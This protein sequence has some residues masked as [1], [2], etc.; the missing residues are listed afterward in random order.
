MR[1]LHFGRFHSETNP[2]GV[3]HYVDS[4]IQ[5]LAGQVVSD[6]LVSG[7]GREA[8]EHLA[9][10]GGRVYEM[11]S[12]GI[13]ASVPLSPGILF[14][15]RRLVRENKYDIIHLNFPDPLALFVAAFLPPEIPIVVT[16]HSDVVKQRFALPI[17]LPILRWFMKRVAAVIVATPRHIE[18]SHQLRFYRRSERIFVVPFGIDPTRFELR[19]AWLPEIQRIRESHAGKKILFALGR[20]VYYKGYSFLLS[21]MKSVE[22]T[23]L[24][25]GGSGPLTNELREQALR[26]GLT[27][28]VEFLGRLESEQIPWY[29]HACDI[30]MFPSVATTEA[31]GYAQIEAMMCAKPV[32][33]CQ[34]NNGVNY[35]HQDGVTGLAVEPKN[36]CDLSRA[37]EQLLGDEE[38]RARFGSA[39]Y[40][41]AV[42]EF[43]LARMGEQVLRIYQVVISEARSR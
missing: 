18:S 10:G 34:L 39:A 4:L 20:H 6:N 36:V 14:R 11:P 16:W 9:L 7:V 19:P 26:D 25:L 2:G 3:Q 35:V 24:L 1:V 30:F 32:I 38:L 42:G 31:F 37:I 28:K 21:A 17:Y 33:C 12:Y 23:V 15:A 40:D 29:L 13:L 41:R 43:S 5:A 27:D 22:N 8:R